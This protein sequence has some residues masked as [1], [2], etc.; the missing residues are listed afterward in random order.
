MGAFINPFSIVLFHP[1]SQGL[2]ADT[3]LACDLAID[4]AIP[5]IP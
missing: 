4:G 2:F 3:E 1:Q 5:R